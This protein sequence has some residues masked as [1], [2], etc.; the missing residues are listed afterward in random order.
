LV[1]DVWFDVVK[2]FIG[3]SSVV[4]MESPSDYGCGLVLGGHHTSN[5]ALYGEPYK[6][7]GMNHWRLGTT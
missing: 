3:S 6:M 7:R 4:A 1:G 2:E 5:E